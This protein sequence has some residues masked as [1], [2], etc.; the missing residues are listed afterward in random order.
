MQEKGR[1][2]EVEADRPNSDHSKLD[3]ALVPS[4]HNQQA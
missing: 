1:M 2:T 3:P 4:H